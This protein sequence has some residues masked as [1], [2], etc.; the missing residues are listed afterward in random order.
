VS[1]GLLSTSDN[2]KTSCC[3]ARCPAQICLFIVSFMCW[4]VAYINRHCQ[5]EAERNNDTDPTG[6]MYLYSYSP[7]LARSASSAEQPFCTNWC[8]QLRRQNNDEDVVNHLWYRSYYT[9]RCASV[10]FGG[11]NV[12][13]YIIVYY[14]EFLRS[15]ESPWVTQFVV[16]AKLQTRTCMQLSMQ[17]LGHFST[18]CVYYEWWGEVLILIDLYY[19]ILFRNSS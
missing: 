4:L 1:I 19:R 11:E 9:P 6:G 14:L 15:I 18:L 13:V 10:I 16:S 12:H 2:V 17:L 8:R 3:F 7:V 5:Q